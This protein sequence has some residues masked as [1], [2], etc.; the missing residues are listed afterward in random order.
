MRPARLPRQGMR[1]APVQPAVSGRMPVVLGEGLCGL[2]G[3]AVDGGLVR[4]CRYARC[5]GLAGVGHAKSS[6]SEFRS[7]PAHCAEIR[8]L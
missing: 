2:G 8:N 4:G 1:P 5:G 6:S 3:T 7:A